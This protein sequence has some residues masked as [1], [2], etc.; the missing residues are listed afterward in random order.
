MDTRLQKGDMGQQP[1]GGGEN[2]EGNALSGK[3]TIWWQSSGGGVSHPKYGDD[4]FF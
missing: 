3:T 1:L 2:A 4:V